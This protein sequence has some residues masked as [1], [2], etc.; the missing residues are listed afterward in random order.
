V[1]SDCVPIPQGFVPGRHGYFVPTGNAA[2]LRTGLEQIVEL[3]A[4]ARAEMGQE[5]FQLVGRHYRIADC[6]AKFV[7]LVENILEKGSSPRV[8]STRPLAT[9]AI[10]GVDG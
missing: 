5:A 3:S 2:A 7:S 10:N 9:S 1:V 6:T 8:R 4:S